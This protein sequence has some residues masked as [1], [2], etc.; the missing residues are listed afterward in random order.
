MESFW[1][2]QYEFYKQNLLHRASLTFSAEE[3]MRC[4]WISNL[5]SILYYE[6]RVAVSARDTPPTFKR[7]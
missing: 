6:L 5:I 1:R 3:E 7:T 2:E 4:R